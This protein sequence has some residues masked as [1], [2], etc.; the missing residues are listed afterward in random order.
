MQV[1]ISSKT[2]LQEHDSK[3]AKTLLTGTITVYNNPPLTTKQGVKRS[4]PGTYN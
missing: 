4:T 3:G 2:M 1:S